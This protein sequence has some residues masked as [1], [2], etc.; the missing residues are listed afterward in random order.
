[1]YK[2]ATMLIVYELHDTAVAK[3]VEQAKNLDGNFR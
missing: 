3:V 1:M 2:Y